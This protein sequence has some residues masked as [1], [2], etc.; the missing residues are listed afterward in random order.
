M[1]L[2]KCHTHHEIINE[3]IYHKCMTSKSNWLKQFI[4]LTFY[5]SRRRI[6]DAYTLAIGHT[7]EL[8]ESVLFF[9]AIYLISA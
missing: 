1:K 7:M 9:V 3:I 4:H 8:T 2:P 6:I 5:K